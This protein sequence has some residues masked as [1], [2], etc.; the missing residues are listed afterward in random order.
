MYWN[1]IGG[2]SVPPHFR[3]SFRPKAKAAVAVYYHQAFIPISDIQTGCYGRN[4]VLSEQFL[5]CRY[6]VEPLDAPNPV[7]RL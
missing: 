7:V 6:P 1:K 3:F 2:L 4:A 5:L